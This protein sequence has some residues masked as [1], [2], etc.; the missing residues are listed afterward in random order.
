M[1]QTDGKGDFEGIEKCLQLLIQVC[2]PKEVLLGLGEHLSTQSCEKSLEITIRLSKY[3]IVKLTRKQSIYM[4]NFCR[5]F[6]SKIIFFMEEPATDGE[7][8]SNWLC[9]LV[10][11]SIDF[12]VAML[13]YTARNKSSELA[14]YLNEIRSDKS[15]D[16][17][18]VENCRSILLNFMFEIMRITVEANSYQDVKSK[19]QLETITETVFKLYSF[20]GLLEMLQYRRDEVSNPIGVIVLFYMMYVD[21]LR[22]CEIPLVYQRSFILSV[23]QDYL[24]E[25]LESSSPY[26]TKVNLG[27]ISFLLTKQNNSFA[28][29]S[30]TRVKKMATCLTKIMIWCEDEHLRKE[31]QNIFLLFLRNIPVESK[32]PILKSIYEES[33]HAGLHGYLIKHISSAV[34]EGQIQSCGNIDIGELA[35]L[36]TKVVVGENNVL[37]E[38]DRYIAGL[39]FVRYWLLREERWRSTSNIWQQVA[40]LNKNISVTV[41]CVDV[42]KREISEQINGLNSSETTEKSEIDFLTTLPGGQVLSSLSN[43]E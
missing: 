19:G 27:L 21:G 34:E 43:D 38:S 8:R 26:V 22:W 28:R 12:V 18:E 39:N 40:R 23:L 1:A 20:T 14:S 9:S 17:Y 29:V 15:W 5:H 11:V 16:S 41:K 30:L 33:Q 2:S 3:T 4:D 32:V 42:S 6:T 7:D 37:Q 35:L 36:F 31:S 24:E 25:S 13:P 10:S